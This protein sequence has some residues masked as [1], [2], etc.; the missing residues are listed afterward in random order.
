MEI[1]AGRLRAGLNE[2]RFTYGWTVE[3]GAVYATSDPRQI[4]WRVE[5]LVLHPADEPGE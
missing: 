5:R 4:A 3:A 2:L 1:G